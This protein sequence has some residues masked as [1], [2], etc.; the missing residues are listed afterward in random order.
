MTLRQPDRTFV[1]K[2]IYKV[3]IFT[4][5]I[6]EHC[7]FSDIE[8]K[9]GIVFLWVAVK[10]VRYIRFKC[11]MW[12]FEKIERIYFRYIYIECLFLIG[13]KTM[14]SRFIFL[15]NLIFCIVSIFLP[16]SSVL[17][18]LNLIH[19]LCFR[20]NLWINLDKINM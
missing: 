3:K 11:K 5:E 4:I 13:M 17:Y 10:T 7:F 8:D 14:K 6:Y 15:R 16:V 12:M 2:K 9:D 20:E 18:I 19:L 1:H